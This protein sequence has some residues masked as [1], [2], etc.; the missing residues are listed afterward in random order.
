MD[1]NLKNY[2][3]RKIEE[4][5]EI[6]DRFLFKKGKK[7]RQRNVFLKL[8][9]FFSDFREDKGEER[10]I[11]IYGLRGV[12][13]T[14]SLFHLYDEITNFF[15]KEQVLYIPCDQL[16]TFGNASLSEA[17][18]VFIEEIHNESMVK[19]KKKLFFLI[20]E[21][22]FD[23]KW[24]MTLKSLYDMN[25]NI[26]IVGTGSAAVSLITADT[27]RRS[28]IIPMFPLNFQEY[29]LLKNE[30]NTETSTSK[31]MAAVIT[32]NL[33][34]SVFSL[35][36]KEKKFQEKL[37]GSDREIKKELEHFINYGCFTSTL[38]DSP[39]EIMIKTISI[40]EKIL[41]EDLGKNHQIHNTKKIL[42]YLSIKKP[43][44]SS[45]SKLS[46]SIG[47]SSSLVKE[48]FESLEKAHLV[49]SVKPKV[50]SAG[51]YARA[52]WKYY[53]MAPAILFSIRKSIGFR[54]DS[55]LIAENAVAA[56]LFRLAQKSQVLSLQYDLGNPKT[57]TNVD[58]LLV[59]SY[60][61]KTIPIEVGIKK[62]KTYQLTDA[63]QR[64]NSNH[65]ILVTTDSEKT[66]HINEKI[67][68]I[69]LSTF[70]LN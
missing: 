6:K 29:Q 68:K 67:T 51:T 70:V 63:I 7:T 28:S 50:K 42:S 31:D 53:F 55:G 35:Q 34:P 24:E 14:T 32:E 19:L 38:K 46:S 54:E 5:E 8:K 56:S 33:T 37:E 1:E 4:A 15:P 10:F 48:I 62:D 43:G 17:L 23:E 21:V 13:K 69:P 41:S 18:R 22:H 61:G 57:K 9:K 11:L 2:L 66:E 27:G 26:F 39:L 52:P 60:S 36:R 16:N 45:Y 59:N 3:I 44:E 47:I 30:I 25:N 20:D 58:F 49:F 40:V 65:G 12:G 64:H